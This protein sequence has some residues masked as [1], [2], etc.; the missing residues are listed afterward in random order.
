[1]KL[2]PPNFSAGRD[3]YRERFYSL[4]PHLPNP[5]AA[6]RYF[7]AQSIWDD[8]MAWNATNFIAANPEQ[9]LVIIVGEFHVWYG[10]GLP[11]RIH[12][13]AP[14]V[15][16]LTFSQV[17]TLDMSDKDIAA[18]IQVSPT[19]GPRSDYLWLAPAVQGK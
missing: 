12:A 2:M 16:V 9:V 14:Q 8:T 5:E 10:G 6:N 18:A 4:M 17:N 13:R 15:P 3:S 1:M 7:L 11:D 19:E